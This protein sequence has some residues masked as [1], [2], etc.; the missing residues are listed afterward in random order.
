MTLHRRAAN[1]AQGRKDKI[2][3]FACNFAAERAQWL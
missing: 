1:Q 3:K 2:G